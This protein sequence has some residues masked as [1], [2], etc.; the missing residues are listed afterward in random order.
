MTNE[1]KDMGQK[2]EKKKKITTSSESLSFF[3]LIAAIWCH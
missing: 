3:S 2:L 1:T